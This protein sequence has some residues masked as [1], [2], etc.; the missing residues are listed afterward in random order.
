MAATQLCAATGCDKPA[1]QNRY[2]AC[3]MHEARMRRGGSFEPR[4]PKMTFESIIGGKS[5]FGHWTV[6]GEGEPYQRKSAAKRYGPIRT[7]I[8][9]CECGTVRT[10]HIHTLKQG[11]SQHCGCR[12]GEKNAELHGKHLMYGTPEYRTWAHMKERCLNQN[13]A[14]YPSYGGRGIMV[15]DRWRDSFEAFF[16]D[17]GARP[18]GHSIE[19]VDVNGNYEPGNCCWATPREQAQNQRTTRFVELAGETLALREACRRIEAPYK[20]IHRSMSNGKTFEQAAARYL[21]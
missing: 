7:A 14:D 20:S 16:A 10:I 6:L 17:M 18:A 13:C 19:R 12:N 21:P 1:R 3:S 9:R 8:C 11:K 5:A 15:C 2:N 4:Q